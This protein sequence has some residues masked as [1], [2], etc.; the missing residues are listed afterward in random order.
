[1]RSGEGGRCWR[2]PA[3]RQR[4]RGS[5]RTRRQA[6]RQGRRQ[7]GHLCHCWRGAAGAVGWRWP[8]G[9]YQPAASWCTSWPVGGTG[10]LGAGAGLVKWGNPSDPPFD[11]VWPAVDGAETRAVSTLRG[12]TRSPRQTQLT[13]SAKCWTRQR[14]TGAGGG[15]FDVEWR[16]QLA[17]LRQATRLAGECPDLQQIGRESLVVE[18]KRRSHQMTCARRELWH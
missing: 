13:E 11:R 4:P 3:C 6:C 5:T 8:A 17:S 1:M 14:R 16:C 2:T 12:T 18:E 15:A 10:G 9:D 7:D